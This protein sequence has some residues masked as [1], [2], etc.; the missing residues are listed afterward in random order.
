MYLG[1]RN[2]AESGKSL[3][4]TSG[5]SLASFSMTPCKP[6]VLSVV[7]FISKPSSCVNL[8][9]SALGLRKLRKI[10]LTESMAVVVRRPL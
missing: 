3:A 7:V 9:A 5:G 8:V 4:R 10:P 2:A 1:G 6:L